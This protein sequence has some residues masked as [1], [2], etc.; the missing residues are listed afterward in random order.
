MDSKKDILDA[1]VSE[2]AHLE[3]EMIESYDLATIYRGNGFNYYVPNK[4][5][6]E[7]EQ[8]LISL[9]LKVFNGSASVSVEGDE[10]T[11]K[12]IDFFK[13]EVMPI[14]EINQ[15]M[16]K[17]ASKKIQSEFTEKCLTLLDSMSFVENKK[18]FSQ[19]LL[20][21]TIGL[22]AIWFFAVDDA[23]E[24]IM[25]NSQTS[26]FVFHK[27][28]GMCKVAIEFDEYFAAELAK[29][30]ASTIDRQFDHDT[31]LL[32]ARLPDGSRVNATF[33]GISPNGTT[34]TIRKF[35]IK[36]ISIINII[37][38]GTISSEAAA[39]L[40]LLTEGFGASPKNILI[41]GGTA[42][43]KTTM[44]NILAG[45][46]KLSDRIITIEDTVE[47]FLP[48]RDNWVPMES[49]TSTGKEIGIDALLK[50]A[51]RMRP[52]RIIVGEVRGA[53]AL[54][55]FNAMDTGHQGCLGNIHANNGR[56][57]ISK[58]QEKPMDVP[59]SLISLLDV[60]V[61][62]QKRFTK[63]HGIQRKIVQIVEVTRMENKVLLG[64]VF[65]FDEDSGMI[66][67]TDVPSSVLEKMAQEKNVSKMELKKELELRKAVL[68][69][70]LKKGIKSQSNSFDVIQ[71][72]YYTREQVL[73]AM[74]ENR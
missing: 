74:Y 4:I 49:R 13:E 11:M 9:V 45:F 31:P 36:P 39:F 7:R 6:N 3:S 69:W 65:D 64:T 19:A 52:D 32:D 23:L 33:S 18:I 30:I 26:T 27:K 62:M 63:E 16:K 67:K 66:K 14:V 1:S 20:H 43:G 48:M 68:D 61:I 8:N 2:P 28:H 73:Q 12:F 10:E 51:M 41:A 72:Y 17:M 56:E 22:G 35:S 57:V 46:I 24:E 55:F 21:L 71:G 37:E 38:D 59:Q 29:K 34:L 53:E 50:N 60:I 15:L 70:M 47:I 58:L 54:T 44:L 40:W 42:S 5:F 25:I